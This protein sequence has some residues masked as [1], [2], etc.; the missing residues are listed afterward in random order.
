MS[1]CFHFSK[2][3]MKCSNLNVSL[4][5]FK[6]HFVSKRSKNMKTGKDKSLSHLLLL[7]GLWD[8]LPNALI[9]AKHNSF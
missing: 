1:V 6:W 9:Q 4:G 3:G 8:L 2:L 7:W 5:L